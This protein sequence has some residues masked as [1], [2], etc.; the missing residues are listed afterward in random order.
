M[1]GGNHVV[2][3]PLRGLED[4][5]A[6]RKLLAEHYDAG[7]EF[8]LKRAHEEFEKHDDYWWTAQILEKLDLPPKGPT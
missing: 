7:Y 2:E 1:G 6:L 3:E 5:P 8:A 4:T